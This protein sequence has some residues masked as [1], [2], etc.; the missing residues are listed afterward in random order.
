VDS[1]PK[2]KRDRPQTRTERRRAA[3]ERRGRLMLGGAVV[4]AILVIVAWF[5]TTALYHQRGQLASATSHLDQLRSQNH[6]LEQERERLSTPAEVA[7]IARQQ[8]Q[9]VFPGQQAYQV[10]TGTGTGT[11]SGTGTGA[12]GSLGLQVPVTPSAESQLPPGSVGSGSSGVVASGSSGQAASGGSSTTSASHGGSSSSFL[13][14]MLQ[15][16]EFWR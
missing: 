15:T 9:L 8:Y 6:A 1:V 2:G 3:Q 16:L 13:D 10:L 14:R 11:G 4:V 5:P 12:T 7:R